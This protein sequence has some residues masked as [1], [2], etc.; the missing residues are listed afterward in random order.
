[1]NLQWPV[2]SIRMQVRVVII[3]LTT[4]ALIAGGFVAFQEREESVRAEKA[5][6]ALAVLE[7]SLQ[8]TLALSLERGKIN[9]G[10]LANEAI[11][12][13]EAS[14]AAKAKQATDIPLAAALEKLRASS[15]EGADGVEK[16]LVGLKAK[17]DAARLSVEAQ[18][19]KNLSERSAG[20]SQTYLTA[21]FALMEEIG[22]I[23][24]RLE[25]ISS[26]Y[27]PA[28]AQRASLAVLAM[29]LRDALGRRSVHITSVVGGGHPMTQSELERW[30]Q[31][32]GHIDE[33]WTQL[34]D[35]IAATSN[36][37]PEVTNAIEEVRGSYF[38]KAAAFYSHIV[39]IGRTSGKYDVDTSK[40][41]DYNI[42]AS[43]PV[44]ALATTAIAD[45]KRVDISI[46]ERATANYHMALAGLSVI[47]VVCLVA[48]F[49]FNRRVAKPLQQIT[50]I[51]LRVAAG[52][53]DVA[54]PGT[55]RGDEIGEMANAVE[56]LR[57]V[58]IKARQL[59]SAQ[60]ANMAEIKMRQSLLDKI[61]ES[62]ELS[63]ASIL[64]QASRADTELKQSSTDLITIADQANVSVVA[65]GEAAE[66]TTST[67]HTVAA[68]AQELALST[69]E[70]SRQMQGSS[71]LSTRA[72]ERV[73][74]AT[75]NVSSLAEAAQ[76]I[77]S[78]VKFIHEIASKTNLLA[79]NATIEAAR[80][81]DAGKGFAVVASEVKALA[82]QTGEAIEQIS[83][84]VANIQTLTERA[85][86]AIN[87][88]GGIVSE[89]D[90]A[91]VAVAAAVEEQSAATSE[92]ARSIETAA[93][94]V[95]AL[96]ANIL[97]LRQVAGD[98]MNISSV[99]AEVS[100]SFR[101][102][103]GTVNDEIQ[104][105]IRNVK[106]NEQSAPDS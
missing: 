95:A 103:I 81:G 78:V 85:V 24:A 46:Y 52:E 20:A 99:V 49:G 14:A 96:D 91:N 16:Q 38:V 93:S 11:S 77:E 53:L 42:E 98:N 92:I 33:L 28:V 12:D 106:N 63:I 61:F 82:G 73:E 75:A 27:A 87:H 30:G 83:A 71:E 44:V 55:G 84:Q 62:F 66:Q 1:M 57:L 18:T 76:E 105:F 45:G 68:A 58:S 90:R 31:L 102:A 32:S 25:S 94:S 86:A 2:L 65:S 29:E 37:S 69:Q 8:L 21:M 47:F 79:L 51:I 74:T 80:A 13:D 101:K 7:D 60:A 22:R 41:R 19:N 35:R 26:D 88:I 40:M 48:F 50:T 54:V 104:L 10:L 4:L 15:F 36:L 6:Q 100:A 97:A 23:N 34:T 72:V 5:G 59:E 89:V 56:T 67:V 17:I 9:L 39:E 70:I 3:V 43:K 64:E